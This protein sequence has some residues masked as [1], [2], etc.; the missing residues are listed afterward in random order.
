MAPRSDTRR[1]RL[2]NLLAAWGAQFVGPA[3]WAHLR[4]SLAPVSESYLR[5]LLRDSGVPLAPLLAGVDIHS[6]EGAE[7]TL[8]ELAG[9]YG[10]QPH[11]ARK[12]VIE[13]KDKLRWALRRHPEDVVKSE[14]LLW[15]MTW[16]ENP[17]SFEL[18]LSLRKRSHAM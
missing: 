17:E 4:E 7:R 1:V 15:V 16:L 13:A 12:C 18:W 3:E 9:E 6:L 10:S 5:R 8:L 14:M 2:A 11:A